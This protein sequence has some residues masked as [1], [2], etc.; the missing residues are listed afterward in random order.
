MEMRGLAAVLSA[1]ILLAA[2]AFA[3]SPAQAQIIPRTVE[4]DAY[5]SFYSF[6]ARGG[7]DQDDTV[8]LE[9]L[10][11]GALVGG[12]F[13]VNFLEWIGFETTIGIM[14]TASDDTLRRAWYMNLHVDAIFHLPFPYVVPYF[15][16]GAGFQYYNIRPE[17]A[18]GNGPADFSSGVFYRDP[19]VDQAIPQAQN[20]YLTYRSADG[21]F[22]LDA[23]GGAKFIIYEKVEPSAGFAVGARLD[24]RWKLSIGPN[25]AEDGVPIRAAGTF[26]PDG[27][28]IADEY[29]GVFNHLELGGG[30]FFLFGGGIGPDRDKDLIP[31]RK[32]ACPDEPED[33]DEF[34]DED[35]CP[36][37]DNDKD[38]IADDSDRC[39]LEPEDKDTWQDDDG[40]P[41]IDN[42][43]DGFF[44]K[45]DECPLDAEDKDGFEDRDGC[46]ELDN[47]GDGF[48]DADDR[49]PTVTEVFNSYL[50]SDGCPDEIPGD[51]VEFA[52][53]IP[54][55]QFL[56]GSAQLKRSALPILKKAAKALRRYPDLH[57]E[58]AG[59]AS[60]EGSAES[61]MLLSQDRTQTVRDYLID[62]GIA[63]ERLAAMGYGETKPVADNDT[64]AGRITNRR[65]EFKLDSMN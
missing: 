38:G 65:V 40:C 27:T 16:V 55:I 39:P 28:P 13:G 26:E 21:D 47:D 50:D 24:I 58:I 33:R 64:E 41:D 7:F 30:V 57:V 9:N 22:L 23:G 49:C 48:L 44:D 20:Q 1:T 60:S 11:D 19:H 54:A 61:N 25:T 53:T 12:R 34:E 17:Y 51:L 46:P 29:R 35:G 14:R 37:H 31:N 43:G 59:H 45:D 52:G 6:I 42:D 5:G 18:R 15:V 36:D 4:I 62:Q 56:V 10:Q 32:D 63:P 8:K 3:A 2:V